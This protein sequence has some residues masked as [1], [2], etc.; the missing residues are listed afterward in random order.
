LSFEQLVHGHE[1]RKIRFRVYT[2]IKL[3]SLLP[4]VLP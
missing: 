1:F 4:E 3:L 2:G